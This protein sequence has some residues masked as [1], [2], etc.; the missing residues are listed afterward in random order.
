M[1]RGP[2][3]TPT[4]LK[5]LRGNP[6]KRPLNTREPAVAPGSV[7][8]PAELQGRARE[9]WAELA[10]ALRAAGCLAVIDRHALA[11]ACRLQALGDHY[12]AVAEAQARGRARRPGPA[13]WAAVKCW[14]QA[15]AIWA[16]FGVT[17]SERSRV[18][19]QEAAGTGSKWGDAL[20]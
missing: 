15:L 13:L 9:L 4:G 11:T 16:R 17:P 3:P 12:A 14:Q 19:V 6:G 5:L 10:P 1:P 20:M 2:A 7:E 8:P 18:Q